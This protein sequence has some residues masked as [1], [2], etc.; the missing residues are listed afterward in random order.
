MSSPTTL[1]GVASTW[2]GWPDPR[3]S[4]VRSLGLSTPADHFVALATA[5]RLILTHSTFGY[6]GAHFSNGL[7]GDNHADVIVPWFHDRT[8]WSGAASQLNPAWTVVK[9]IP[10]WLER[11]PRGQHQLDASDRSQPGTGGMIA[12][13]SRSAP[14]SPGHPIVGGLGTRGAVGS[15]VEPAARPRLAQGSPPGP[16]RSGAPERTAQR[17]GLGRGHGAQR[18]RHHRHDGASPAG[19]GRGAHPRGRQ[20]IDGRHPA[21]PP[22]GGRSQAARR[23][24]SR[25]RLLPGSQDDSADQV[26]GTSRRQLGGAVRC[27]RAVVRRRHDPRDAISPRALPRPPEQTS[28][29]HSLPRRPACGA[30]NDAPTPCARW[31]SGL[32]PWRSSTPEITGCPGRVMSAAECRSCTC[33]GG[34]ASSW[35]ASSRQGARCHRGGREDRGLGGHWQ[36]HGSDPD[37]ELERIWRDLKA[38]RP[39]PSLSWAPSGGPTVRCPSD[40][41]STWTELLPTRGDDDA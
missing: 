27:R 19:P 3:R 11:P 13:M 6:W 30:S 17:R 5:R 28:T 10:G 35:S 41:L 26:G 7:Y 14:R 29:T 1:P 31:R 4:H 15:L 9:D 34:R 32:I 33:R 38:G 39:V 23:P 22:V 2:R 20:R 36:R 40:R 21:G 8:M 25:A 24:R 12:V 16:S 37:D 18:E